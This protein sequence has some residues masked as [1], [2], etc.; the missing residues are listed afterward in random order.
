MPKPPEI[1]QADFDAL[2]ATIYEKGGD[3][4]FTIDP[5]NGPVN[6][7]YIREIIGE[8][9]SLLCPNCKQE[10]FQVKCNDKHCD[11]HHLPLDAAAE[12]PKPQ[13]TGP[14]IAPLVIADIEARVKKGEETYGEKLRAFNGR[15]M[16]LD[17]YQEALDLCIY[18]RGKLYE[19]TG[20]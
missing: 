10:I 19:E 6:W 1:T 4:E 18:L 13:G 11:T 9:Q 15:S 8:I 7:L 3:P 17:A 2:L 20:R 14:E 16:I 5:V 12:Q